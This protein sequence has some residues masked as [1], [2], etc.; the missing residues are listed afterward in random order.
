MP[1]VRTFIA[2]DLSAEI[3]SRI[4]ELIDQL[5]LAEARVSWTKPGNVHLTLK[6]LGDTDEQRL[7]DVCRAVGDAARGTQPVS[8]RVRGLG[9][10]P[11]V[12]R[13]RTIWVGIAEG[14]EEIGAL[15]EAVAG[16]LHALGFPRESRPF[17]PHVTVGRVRERVSGQS[18][19]IRRLREKADF[20]GGSALVQEVVVY[21]SLLRP[22][23]PTYQVLGRA[24]LAG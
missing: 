19:L 2:V 23:G 22:E 8:I 14:A 7:P 21:A 12:Q 20:E 1:Q 10:F 11:H 5:R 6:F 18:E 9:A 4:Q 24:P 15:A 16:A 3:C 17:S 13:P